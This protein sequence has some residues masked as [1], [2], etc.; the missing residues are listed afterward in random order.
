[1]RYSVLYGFNESKTIAMY[2][3]YLLD[4]VVPKVP[5]GAT[6]MIHGYTD[7]L[8]ED[9]YNLNLSIN[10]ANDVCGIF[11]GAWRKLVGPM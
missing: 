9:D 2:E 6:V 7:V 10:R 5:M 1:M 11:K 3:K 8:G 4:V